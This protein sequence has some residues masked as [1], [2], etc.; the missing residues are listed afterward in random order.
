MIKYVVN[1][2]AIHRFMVLIACSTLCF[3]TIATTEALANSHGKTILP[4]IKQILSDRIEGDPSAPITMIEYASMTCPHCAEFHTGAYKLIKKEYVETGKVKFIY[5][6]FPLDRLGLAAA[7]MARC[8]PKERYFAIVN[9]IYQSQDSWARASDPAAA[10]AQIANL[11]GMSKKTF[12]AC[13]IDKNI[14]EGVMKIRNDGDKKFNIKA[15]PTILID[16]KT[17]EGDKTIKAFRSELNALLK[18]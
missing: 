14:Y 9:I 8:A 11:A 17:F 12:D 7:M 13:I 16:G 10:L 5:R 18:K 15:T 4:P 1:N 6:D 2:F 3:M